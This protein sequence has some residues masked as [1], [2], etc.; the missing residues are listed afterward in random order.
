MDF[1]KSTME[2]QLKLYAAAVENDNKD[3]QRRLEKE[4]VTY[5]KQLKGDSD[6]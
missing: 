1:Y 5:E 3:E 2:K 4:I 6:E